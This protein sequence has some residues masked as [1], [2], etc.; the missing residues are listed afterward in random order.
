MIRS[1]RFDLTL[2]LADRFLTHPHHLMHKAVGW[3]LRE[4]GKRH[5]PLLLRLPPTK[6]AIKMPRTALRHAID[7]SHPDLPPPLP[8]RKITKSQLT[9]NNNIVFIHVI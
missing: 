9:I 5:E 7:A 2:C 1:G 3:M 6:D 4:V 8:H